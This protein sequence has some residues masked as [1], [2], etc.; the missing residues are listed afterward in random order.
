MA[1]RLEM[2]RLGSIREE[3]V[4]QRDCMPR[5]IGIPGDRRSPRIANSS[6]P[7]RGPS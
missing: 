1:F 6:G 5:E 2:W 4:N 7:A 3:L